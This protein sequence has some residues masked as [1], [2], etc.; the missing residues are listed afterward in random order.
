[1]FVGYGE[2]EVM[3][4]TVESRAVGDELAVGLG[5]VVLGLLA[6]ATAVKV[7]IRRGDSFD[8]DDA[9]LARRV[10]GRCGLDRNGP[11]LPGQAMLVDAG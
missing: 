4:V 7:F 8:Y 5:P 2:A 1:M 10:R 6:G 11:A 3:V 9:P